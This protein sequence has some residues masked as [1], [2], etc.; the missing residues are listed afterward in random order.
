VG[1]ADVREFTIS[2]TGCTDGSRTDYTFLNGYCNSGNVF[3]N[4]SFSECFSENW[5]LSYFANL[6]SVCSYGCLNGTCL[7]N[8]G[9]PNV[10][11]IS[12]IAN[13]VYNQSSILFNFSVNGSNLDSV[14]FYLDGNRSAYNES[15]SL[16][17]SEGSYFLNVSANNTFGDLGYSSVSFIV[18]L[19]AGPVTCIEDWVFD[20]WSDCIDGEQTK[21]WKD[22]NPC[23][24]TLFRPATERRSCDDDDSCS[25]C[26]KVSYFDDGSISLNGFHN[27]TDIILLNSGAAVKSDDL[28]LWFWIILLLILILLVSFLVWLVYYEKNN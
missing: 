16:N 20:G 9:A 6:S 26:G 25:S 14:W 17:L 27:E 15:F 13:Y 22:L 7:V 1:V 5:N 18:N 19:S 8:P 2:S 24:T 21:T 23:G 10:T 11:I 12:P 3:G 28:S 4:Y